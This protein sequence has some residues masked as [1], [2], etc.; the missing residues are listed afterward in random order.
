MKYTKNYDIIKEE[1]SIWENIARPNQM[2]PE[3]DWYVW[4]IMAGR[5]FGKTRTAAESVLKLV[6]SGRYKNVAIIGKTLTETRHVMVESVSGILQNSK[7]P[8]IRYFSSRR[9]IVWSNGAKATLIAGDNYESMRGYQFDLVWVDEF[10]KFQDPGAV[11]EQIMFT[12]R[13]GPDPRCIISTTP[14]PLEILKE[15]SED[16]MTHLTSGSTFDNEM[17]L[18]AKFV[19]MVRDRFEGTKMG[20]SELYGELVM[21]ECDNIWM[22]SDIQYKNVDVCEMDR[23][24]VGVDPAV[25]NGCDSDETGIVVAGRGS[26]NNIYILEDA[27][28]HYSPRDWARKVVNVSRKYNADCIVAEVNNGGDLV[29]EMIR[30]VDNLIPCVS[31]RAIRGKEMRA[32]PVAMMYSSSKIFHMKKFD[33]LESQML[34][35]TRNSKGS[36]DRVDA[37]VWAVMH[38]NQ[39]VYPGCHVV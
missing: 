2:I 30:G 10:A 15:L 32:E 20:A 26:D 6:E 31:V 34:G 12:L 5:G 22:R 14:K 23:I 7:D 13:I 37:M 24:V 19:E 3:G 17:N 29:S 25:T 16:R 11:W 9:Q 4:L 27:S 1:G 18:P 39:N 38:L 8:G 35:F 33:A 28:G 36:P 21:D